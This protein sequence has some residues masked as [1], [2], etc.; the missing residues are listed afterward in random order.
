VLLQGS[1]HDNPRHFVIGPLQVNE[2]HMPFLCKVLFLG[3]TFL[4]IYVAECVFLQGHMYLFLH[5]ICFYSNIFGYETKV[6]ND[7]KAEVS[8]LRCISRNALTS[9]PSSR[10]QYLCK[11]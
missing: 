1:S 10:K 9:F 7:L 8:L 11:R 6:M 5:H 3:A 2:D 4:M